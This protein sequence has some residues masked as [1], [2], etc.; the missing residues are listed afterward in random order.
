MIEEMLEI[1]V[2]AAENYTGLSL[3]ES[4]WKMTIN[5]DLPTQ[6]ALSHGPIIKVI[7]FNIYTNGVS[8]E[9]DDYNIYGEMISLNKHYFM[10]KAEIIYQTGYK[11]L[12]APIRQGIL[13][14][15][16]KLYDLR[17]GDQ[18]MPLAAKSLYQAYKI[19]R[20]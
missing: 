5:G 12:P 18:A 4:I 19:V 6:I 10:S 9:L 17:G 16:A 11:I 1:A 15:L 7:S 14:H 13:E 20:F 3:Q 2:I 8:S